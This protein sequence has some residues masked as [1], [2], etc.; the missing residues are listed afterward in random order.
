MKILY[1]MPYVP[2]PPHSGGAL[3]VFHLLKNIVRHHEVTVLSFGA[4]EDEARM[5]EAF[6]SSI[7]RLIIVPKPWT[8]NARRIA[9]LYALWSDK[10]FFELLAHSKEMEKTILRTL[11]SESFDFVQTEFSHMGHYR[12]PDG[13]VTVLDAHNIENEIFRQLW[14]NARSPLRRLH[15]K[16]EYE[17]FFRHEIE[18]CRRQNMIFTTSNDDKVILDKHC[19][20]VPKFVIPNGVD[21]GYFTAGGGAVEPDTLVF[22]GMMGYLPNHDG[23]EYFLDS[24][25]P[26]ILKEIPA[27]RL[28]VVGQAPPASLLKRQ[29]DHV[30]VTGWVDDVRPYI[31]RAAVY[32][33]PLRMGSGTRLKILEAMSMQKPIV[34]T[35][36]GCEGIRIVHGETALVADD[37]ESF[38]AAVVKLLRNPD[39][40]RSM[41]RTGLDL[42]KTTYDWKVIGESMESHY[43]SLIR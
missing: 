20:S 6:G 35:S 29:N 9:Q 21:T 27:V 12:L 42:V 40:R 33:V 3:R 14:Q 8:R 34:T 11:E 24:I 28:Y 13:V 43:Q 37:P 4:P 2:V 10:S 15:Y 19:P 26:L 23:I 5:K 36:M 18:I 30:C 38:A 31:S 41:T 22:T 32:V 39:L 16:G 1:L 7:K 25:F 17:K